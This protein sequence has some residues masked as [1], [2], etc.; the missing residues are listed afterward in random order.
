MQEMDEAML[1]RA[2]REPGVGVVLFWAVWCP[3]CHA[4]KAVLAQLE[5]QMPQVYFG[6]IDT[7]K[8]PAIAERFRVRSLPTLL[9]LQKGCEVARLV[10]FQPKGRVLAVLSQCQIPKGSRFE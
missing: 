10:G 7:E 9:I 1:E 3:H 5:Q 6:Q 8:R 4:Q 2:S